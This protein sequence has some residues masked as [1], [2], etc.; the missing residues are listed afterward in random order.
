MQ[1]DADFRK[2]VEARQKTAW[3]VL[4]ILAGAV[5]AVRFFLME[6]ASATYDAYG[7]LFW[8]AAGAVGLQVIAPA[9]IVLWVL[10]AAIWLG[11]RRQPDQPRSR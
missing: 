2:L 9:L 4:S 1:Q 6:I 8:W 11:A 5:L 10:W 3:I 7:W